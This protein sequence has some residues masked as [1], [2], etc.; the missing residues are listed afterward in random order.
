[1]TAIAYNFTHAKIPYFIKKSIRERE[2]DRDRDRDRDRESKPASGNQLFFRQFNISFKSFK[3]YL[4]NIILI[5]P[6][7][8]L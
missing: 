7:Q 4:L 3:Y 6:E 2:R 1:M 8:M 5:I